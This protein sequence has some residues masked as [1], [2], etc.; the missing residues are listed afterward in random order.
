ME[1]KKKLSV[2]SKIW[3]EDDAG[4]VVFGAGRLRILDAIARHGSILAAAR[5]LRM[6][7][8]AVWGKIKATEE[9]LG[10]PLLARKVG[11]ARGGGSELT[12]LG[13]TLLARFRQ[14][15]SLTEGAADTMFQ[16]VFVDGL[17]EQPG[18]PEPLG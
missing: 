3:I 11:G 9:R 16:D 2:K 1:T 15:R 14:L 7:Y 13:Q 8:R 17:L 10:R 4:Q 18:K 12:P 5:E 6:S